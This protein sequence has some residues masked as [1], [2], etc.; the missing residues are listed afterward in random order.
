MFLL[1]S[2]GTLGRANAEGWFIMLIRPNRGRLTFMGLALLLAGCS[3]GP[4]VDLTLHDSDRGT[5][6]LE[7]IPDRNFQAAHPV[8]LAPGTLNRVLRGILVRDEHGLLKNLIAGKA[9]TYRVFSD[10]EVA[11]LA[12]L[13]V[14]GLTRAAADQQV[15]FKIPQ[16]G[17]PT[18]SERTGAAVGSSEPPLRL[19]PKEIT[20]GFLYA[21]GRSLYVTITQYRYRPEPVDT[22]NMP[23]RRIPDE[24]GLVDRKILFTPETAKRPASYGNPGSTEATLVIDYALLAALPA[25]TGPPPPPVIPTGGPVPATGQATAPPVVPPVIQETTQTRERELDEMKKEL[26]DIKRQ[27]AEQEAERNAKKQKGSSKQT[28]PS[29]P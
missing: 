4:E 2:C 22:I 15:G 23:N 7:R 21:Y 5:I 12:P 26:Q 19:A 18:Y 3:T 29:T 11:Y 17:G 16:T 6:T 24:T 14:D 28:P 13:L 27:L 25:D 10:D 20:S 1:A 8:K 9:E